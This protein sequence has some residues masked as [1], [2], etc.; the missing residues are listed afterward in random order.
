MLIAAHRFL[1][2]LKD[3]PVTDCW[4]WQGSCVKRDGYGRVT[5]DGRLRNAHRVAW[6]MANDPVPEGQV[7]IPCAHNKACCNPAHLKLAD[8]REQMVENLRK[9]RVAA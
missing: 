5:V 6:E 8:Q 4:L 9:G 3:D 7:V 1:A 2:K